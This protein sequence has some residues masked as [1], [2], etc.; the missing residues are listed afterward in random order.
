[1]NSGDV[2]KQR[3]ASQLDVESLWLPGLCK[4]QFLSSVVVART[5]VLKLW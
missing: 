2:R 1:M 5:M 4:L 3:F